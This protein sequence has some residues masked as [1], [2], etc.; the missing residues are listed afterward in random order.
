[1]FCCREHPSAHHRA[2]DIG[3]ALRHGNQTDSFNCGIV[4]INTIAH[5]V[6]DADL[7]TPEKAV[8]ERAEWFLKLAHTLA[9]HTDT[10]PCQEPQPQPEIQASTSQAPKQNR[11]TI[12][13]LLNS[14]ESDSSMG[15]NG[16]PD[17]NDSPIILTDLTDSSDVNSLS[18]ALIDE[19]QLSI[20]DAEGGRCETDSLTT[21][22]DDSNGNWVDPSDVGESS[23]C[24]GKR[25]DQS[26]SAEVSSFD[27]LS[28]G[29]I[30]TQKR[31][32]KKS[33]AGKGKSK[34]SVWARNKRQDLKDGKLTVDPVKLQ[35]W[36]ARVLNDDRLAEF[37]PK[38]PCQVR[39]SV[40]G[41]FI[42]VKQ[43]Y[44]LTRW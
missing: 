43:L 1:M 27:G 34:S 26:S 14:D 12:A 28:D 31:V 29:E 10:V 20:G 23:V 25:L 3:N 24:L 35:Q 30:A 38:D 5:N 4:A 44:D 11:M 6:L 17:A 19:C 13:S 21:L 32:W 36:K 40:C 7:W 41:R 39:H 37:N 18:M 33:K 2:E 8:R 22:D 42:S 15:D 9:P 16:F